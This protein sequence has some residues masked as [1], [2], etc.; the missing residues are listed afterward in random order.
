MAPF[1]VTGMPLKADTREPLAFL[2]AIGFRHHLTAIPANGGPLKGICVKLPRDADRAAEW[3][4]ACNAQCMG[5]YWTANEVYADFA[6]IKA[7][8]QDVAKVRAVWLDLDCDKG[9]TEAALVARLRA[10]NV[11]PSLLVHSGGGL[12]PVW[13]LD[14][15][16]P[17]DAANVNALEAL[18]RDLRMRLGG[19]A[20]EDVARVLRLPGTVNWPNEAKRER[21]RIPA[22]ARRLD[23]FNGGPVLTGARVSLAMLRAA[24]DA[25]PVL[26]EGEMAAGRATGAGGPVKLLGPRPAT[27]DDATPAEDNV[28]ALEAGM[29]PRKSLLAALPEDQRVPFLR[30]AL[31]TVT[32]H[33]GNREPWMQTLRALRS[34]EDQVPEVHDFALAWSRDE[35][36]GWT[37][38]ADFEKAWTTSPPRPGGTTV[39]TLLA[40]AKSAGLDMARW[41]A[42]ADTERTRR[43]AQV[44]SAT[45]AGTS[46]AGNAATLPDNHIMGEVDALTWGNTRFAFVR[47]ISS[48]VAVDGA[49][50]V[51]PLPDRAFALEVANRKVRVAADNTVKLFPFGPWWRQHTARREVEAIAFDPEGKLGRAIINLDQG[52]GVPPGKGECGLMIRHIHRVICRRD[53]K[54]FK[55]LIRWLAF[56]VQRRGTAPGV[57]VI[58]QSRF[59]GTGKSTLGDAMVRILGGHGLT[60]PTPDALLGN[61]NGQLATASFVQA[62]E[63]SFAGNHDMAR[64]LKALLTDETLLV[65]EKYQPARRVPNVIHLLMTT[66]EASVLIP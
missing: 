17:A 62:S 19:D 65:N 6:G 5:V 45:T 63:V 11:A 21:G 42:M 15:P 48:I 35:A 64:K 40:M 51:R 4:R 13:L 12:Q 34:V 58:L 36:P 66:N 49:G 32:P 10:F 59:E 22:L 27:F 2:A 31:N 7:R 60:V 28:R 52:L 24:V 30:A 43:I 9:A 3:I 55:Y 54:A 44:P 50:K 29:E 46:G 41:A 23:A 20:V 8:K 18:G 39:G 16:V 37:G 33:C 57:A 26:P 1:D 47:D 14:Q 61:F 56:A 53:Q 25:A 38:E